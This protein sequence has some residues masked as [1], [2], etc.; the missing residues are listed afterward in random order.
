M[1]QRRSSG[2]AEEQRRCGG[3]AKEIE[4]A[5]QQ[6]H[7]KGAAPLQ[8]HRWGEGGSGAAEEQRRCSGT[9]DEKQA[10]AQQR[11]ESE[12]AEAMLQMA[13]SK[14]GM[15]PTLVAL[16]ASSVPGIPAMLRDW[17]TSSR[18]E[19]TEVVTLT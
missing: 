4:E 8:R 1:M 10:A 16:E 6:R 7:G 15:P 14:C 2:T 5:A 9:A 19:E 3:K 13:A 17:L 11:E 18:R 12:D